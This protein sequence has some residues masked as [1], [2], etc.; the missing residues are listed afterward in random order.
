MIHCD[1]EKMYGPA[2]GSLNNQTADA[3]IIAE[4]S[5]ISVDWQR[6]KFIHT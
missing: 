2:F 5:D 6:K 1:F 3:V 4:G